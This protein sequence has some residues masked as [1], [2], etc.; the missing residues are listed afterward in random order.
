MIDPELKELLQ[1]DLDASQESLSILKKMRRAQ[2]LSGV[3]TFFKWVLIIGVSFGA[4]Y[5]TQPYL[6]KVLDMYSQLSSTV[7]EVQKAGAKV[8]GV[9]ASSTDLLNKLQG[10]LNGK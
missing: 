5:Y 10:L 4:F 1:K 2:V 3:G 9:T 8:N 6:N 7:K